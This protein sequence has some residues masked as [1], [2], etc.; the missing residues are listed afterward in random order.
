MLW[1]K[2]Y[3]TQD[4]GRGLSK[5][6]RS[7]T[8]SEIRMF[9]ITHH[10]FDFGKW[11]NKCKWTESFPIDQLVDNKNKL[12]KFKTEEEAL[13]ELVEWGVDINFAMDNGVTIERI[14]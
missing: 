11:N 7:M 8:E 5:A 14:H 13:E 12:L 10:R 2:I 1:Q 4:I 3:L 6:K 9:I